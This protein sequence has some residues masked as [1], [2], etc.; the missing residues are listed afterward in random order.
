MTVVSLDWKLRS[1]GFYFLLSLSTTLPNA[2]VQPASNIGL[3]NVRTTEDH[4]HLA[5]HRTLFYWLLDL[6]RNAQ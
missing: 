2:E 3:G 5:M 6:P 1:Q 4:G